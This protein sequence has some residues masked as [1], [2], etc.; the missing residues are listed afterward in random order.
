MLRQ[1]KI[2]SLLILM[3]TATLTNKVYAQQPDSSKLEISILTCDYGHDF[4][5]AFGHVAI[6]VKDFKR[7]NDIIFDYGTFTF[8]E[9]FFVLKF[10]RGDLLYYLSIR[11]FS[12]FKS[13]YTYEN[14]TVTEQV[15][16]LTAEQKTRIFKELLRNYQPQNRYYK[17]DFIT[18][19]CA[20]RIRDIFTHQDFTHPNYT[21]DT[22]IHQL[23]D[24]YLDSKKWLQFGIDV[25]L[26][27]G[28]DVNATF[29]HA[30]YLP[31]TIQSNLMQYTNL[32]NSKRIADEPVILLN[33]ENHTKK[34]QPFQPLY[35]FSLI[36]LIL[37]WLFFK[38]KNILH[39]IT[40]IFYT[41]ISIVGI[42]MIFMWFCSRYP[43]TKQNW[44]ILWA[45]PLYP[46]LLFKFKQNVKISLL[47]IQT[48]LLAAILLLGW[49]ALPQHINPAVYPLTAIIALLNINQIDWLKNSTSQ[50]PAKK[51]GRN[52]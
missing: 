36:F 52:L 19:N 33:G 6:R 50:K 28:I 11:E 47:K 18:D 16:N 40:P 7:H 20:T 2:C 49:W 39:R 3:A 5:T 30:M 41:L 15:L 34:I 24:F 31:Y 23:L 25:L 17:Y 32:K 10:M 21:S 44:N 38:Q 1:L 46:L 27:Q 42:I 9:P 51:R 22:T 35:L 43:C 26:G 37:L 4:A 14:R 48:A 13:D 45:L 29:T 8:N 12:R